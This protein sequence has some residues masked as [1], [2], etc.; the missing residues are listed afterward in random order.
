MRISVNCPSYKRPK[1]ETLDY[2]PFCKVWVCETEA[3]AYRG[4]NPGF[5][6]NIIPCKK[7]IQGNVSRIRNH[8]LDT[9][10]AN[11]ADVVLIIDDDMKW[12]GYFESEPG[13]PFGYDR[14]RLS[15]D[16]FLGFVEHY[17]RLCSEFGFKLWGLNCNR[18]ALSYSHM[19][20][21]S[22]VSFLGCPFHCFL[23]GNE[24]RYDENLP[25]KEDYDMTIQNCNKY[26]GCLRVNK[27]H[28]M[29]KQAEQ[30]GGCA[31]MRNYAKEEQQLNALRKK[32]GSRIVKIDTTNKSNK[33]RI[34][35]EK[36]NFDFNPIIKVP[37][38]GV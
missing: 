17:S 1:V 22:T 27:Y 34:K 4:A 16:D 31:T 23:R 7:G 10:F 14:H 30:T 32:W 11:G 25:L 35:K 15:S 37:I 26:R 2:L 5:E 3:E 6:E 33:G 8:I 20:P 18:D 21:F 38:K 9:E 19:T 29:V 36:A 13:N 28:Y 24:C 12:V